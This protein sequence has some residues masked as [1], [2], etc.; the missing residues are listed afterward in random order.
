M[1]TNQLIKFLKRDKYSKKYFCGVLPFNKLPIK[2]I[3]KPCS[4]I[5]NSHDST[6]PG[7]HWFAIYVPR[8]GKI[9]YFD[10]YGLKPTNDFVLAFIKANKLPYIYNE[11]NIQAINSNTCGK[12]CVFYIYMRSRGFTMKKITNFFV[13]NKDINESFINNLFKKFK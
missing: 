5:I 10:S 7:E 13:S 12:Y 8:R 3:K 2:K 4:F 6:L 9:E 1:D 11:K